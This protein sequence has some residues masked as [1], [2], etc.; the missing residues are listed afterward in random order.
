VTRINGVNGNFTLRVGDFKYVDNPIKL[1]QNDGNHFEITLRQVGILNSE[2]NTN[3]NDEIEKVAK[4]AC[5]S[6]KSNGFI[7]YYGLQRFGKGTNGSHDL[8]KNLFQSNYREFVNNILE[9]S[10]IDTYGRNTDDIIASKNAYNIEKN[11][12]K[13]LNLMPNAM[14]AERSVL[15]VLAAATTTTA[16]D[17]TT[18]DFDDSIYKDAATSINKHTRLL[19]LHAYQSYLWNNAVTYRFEHHGMLPVVGDLVLISQAQAQAQT[20]ASTDADKSSSTT[21]KDAL[22][23]TIHAITA[24]DI[25]KGVY[26]ITDVVLPLPGSHVLHP[27]WLYATNKNTDIDTDNIIESGFYIDL[28]K[29]DNVTWNN[30]C[31]HS[32]PSY[33]MRGDYRNMLEIPKDFEYSFKYYTS[34]M[35]NEELW[36]TELSMIRENEIKK[37]QQKAED[38]R[39]M[40]NARAASYEN[41]INNIYGPGDGDSATATAMDTAT[42]GN[43]NDND[44][45]PAD[46]DADADVEDEDVDTLTNSVVESGQQ[47]EAHK[48]IALKIRFSLSAGAYATMV[49][50]EITKEDTSTSHQMG[51]TSTVNVDLGMTAA[52]IDSEKRKRSASGS[53]DTEITATDASV[54]KKVKKE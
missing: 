23:K 11:Y 19:Y 38:R 53:S 24:D 43:N 30:L 54:L 29:K 1:G 40:L 35:V 27:T 32:D 22:G 37:R 31:N 50:R 16:V 20:D 5:E 44:K 26:S 10:D 4:N 42:D 52:D 6:L 18:G 46:A 47:T 45:D 36:D 8:G 34:N 14:Y 49:L 39:E 9:F 7:N 2:G 15:S 13:A 33:Q 3:T 48:H 17:A 25:S 41:K 28:M 12:I 21:T 51:L